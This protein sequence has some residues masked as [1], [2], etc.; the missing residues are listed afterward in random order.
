MSLYTFSVDALA[1]VAATAKTAIELGT[2][3]S[4]R[5]KVVEWW[6][7]FDGVTATAVPVKCDVGR[8]SATATTATTGT[9][10]KL[11]LADGTPSTV[12]RH[13][14]TVEGAGTLTAGTPIHRISPT[15]GLY[16]PIALGRE[17]LLPVSGFWRIRLTAAA[18]VN[19]TVGVTW[20][21]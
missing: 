12:V 2:S 19:C 10:D 15:S 21:E 14:A 1:L 3:A 16:V 9:A 5:I 13:S 8:F 11:D 18:A 7:E 17:M 6:I 4:A 20:E